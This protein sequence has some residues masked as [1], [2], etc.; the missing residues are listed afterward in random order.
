MADVLFI[1]QARMGSERFPGKVLKPIG[2]YTILDM[3]VKRVRQSAYYD[4]SRDNLIIATSD[5]KTDDILSAHCLSKHYRVHRG[6][7][8]RVLDR[9]AQVI[10]QVQ[11]AIAVRLTGDN[12]FVD[13]SLLDLLIKS[14][15]D[16]QADY[17][18]IGGTPL[19]IGGEA[20][21][22]NLLTELSAAKTLADKYQEHVT[23]LIRE[24]PEK[25]R[26]LFPEPPQE[27]RAPHLR[28]TVDT[29]E[30]YR[31]ARELYAKAGSS[32][33][34]PAKELI[35]L[36]NSDPELRAINQMIRQKEAD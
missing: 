6:S 25:Y 20:V 36:L 3:I 19:G 28:L 33:D 15:S 24:S 13:P 22:A 35:H 14:H 32:P 1:I 8:Q 16:Q 2:G 18:Y 31:L 11:P 5:S 10:E 21:N 30:D 12:P 7:E 27:L 26:L 9:F 29:E 23:L 4:Q 17:T 34:I